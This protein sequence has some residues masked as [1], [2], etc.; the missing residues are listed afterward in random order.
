MSL[1]LSEKLSFKVAQNK[2][3]Q[4]LTPRRRVDRGNA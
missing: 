3:Y 2:V 1:A 4:V